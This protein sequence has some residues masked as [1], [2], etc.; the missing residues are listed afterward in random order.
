MGICWNGESLFDEDVVTTR[1]STFQ[2]VAPPSDTWAA[3][4]DLSG[5]LEAKAKYFIAYM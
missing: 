4:T 5:L 1:F 2:W 3:L